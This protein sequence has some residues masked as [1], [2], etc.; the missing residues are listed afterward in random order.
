M[1]NSA[2]FNLMYTIEQQSAAF[3]VVG[4]AAHDLARYIDQVS[5]I[6]DLAVIQEKL[7]EVFQRACDL[8]YFVKAQVRK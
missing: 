8:E 3:K 1:L 7:A 5:N 6:E 2:E 4:I